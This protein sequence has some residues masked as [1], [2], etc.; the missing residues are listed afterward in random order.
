MSRTRGEAEG[1]SPFTQLPFTHYNGRAMNNSAA[2]PPEALDKYRPVLEQ[3]MQAL[4][5]AEAA[6]TDALYT[7]LRYHMGWIDQHGH[8][9]EGG[10]AGKALRPTLCFLTCEG[11]GCPWPQAATAAATLEFI[12]NFTL[13]HDD[14]QD[15]DVERRGKPTVWAVWGVGPALWAGNAMRVLSDR[16]L[17]AEGAPLHKRSQ[18]SRLLTEA[19]LEILEGQYLDLEFERRAE[20]G[21]P[22]YLDMISRK[23]GALIRCSVEMGALLATEDRETAVALRQ[24]AVHL[25]RAFQVRDDILGIWGDP[26]LTGK[27]VGNDIRR[28][29]KT[30]PVMYGFERATG[31]GRAALQSVY[32]LPDLDQGCVDIVLAVLEESGA[33]RRAQALVD[34]ESELALESLAKVTERLTPCA[35]QQMVQLTY[36]LARRD[37]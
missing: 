3:A 10:S 6:G 27:A 28:K 4:V 18:A 8:V 34:S 15:G 13:I 30:F 14:I 26:S 21:V 16:A 12:H 23:T 11:L 2:P 31:A 36:F 37:K 25:G 22:E 5:P 7:M 1:Q 19:Y 24:W 32:A 33:D 20:V 35:H 9:L 17:A 29:K